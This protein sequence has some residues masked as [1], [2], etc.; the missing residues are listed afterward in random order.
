MNETKP[1]FSVILPVYN[2]A[3]TLSRAIVS[4]LAQ[5]FSDY[6]LLVIENASEDN[7]LDIAKAYEKSFDKV[8][9]FHSWQKGVSKA[10]N[11]GLDNASGE[12]VVFLDAD[13]FYMPNA[14]KTMRAAIEDEDPDI[15]IAAFTNYASNE[16]ERRVR[17]NGRDL[18][19]A[20]LNPLRYYS[21]IVDGS[22]VN[23]FLLR[24]QCAKAYRRKML[25]DSQVRFN[26]ACSMYVDLI[27]NEAAYSSCTNAVLIFKK[28]YQY[29]HVSGSIVNRTGPAFIKDAVA[30]FGVLVSQ[31]D[32]LDGERS[33]AVLFYAFMVIMQ[34]LKVQAN[35]P[36]EASNSMLEAF[37]SSV[38]AQRVICSFTDRELHPN[39]AVND[40]LRCILNMLTNN[41]IPG[42]LTLL[43]NA[44]KSRTRSKKNE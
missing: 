32:S 39:P 4:I 44:G 42:L 1:Y 7:S 23:E 8:R 38:D 15:L 24:H 13:D 35:A 5:T 29:N 6:E 11:I 17:A 30:A 21:R 37:L 20:M 3:Q 2:G 27:F 22:E 34:M 16:S 28:L 43:S 18:F 25:L 12:Y 40:Q 9:V 31:L 41:D 14:L 33:D 26:E 19:L 36:I 10:R